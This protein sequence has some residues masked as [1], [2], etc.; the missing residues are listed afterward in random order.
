MTNIRSYKTFHR[1]YNENKMS[2]NQVALN[3]KFPVR[4]IR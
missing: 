2:G 1:L 3:L 4:R